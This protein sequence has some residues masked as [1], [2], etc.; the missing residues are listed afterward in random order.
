M[1][2]QVNSQLIKLVQNMVLDIVMHNAHMISNSSAEKQTLKD[3]IHHHQIQT[4]VKENMDHAVL[5]LIS[6]RLIRSHQ[7]IHH[8]LATLM[9]MVHS[10]APHQENVEMVIVKQLVNVI[11]MDVISTHID[12]VPKISLVQE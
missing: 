5:S 8:I 9:A 7:P 3:G 2:E 10:D 1:V 6:G 12:S 11:K 4:L